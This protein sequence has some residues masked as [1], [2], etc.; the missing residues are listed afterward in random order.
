MTVC[1]FD[2]DDVGATTLNNAAGS[3]DAVLYSALVTGYNAKSIT[4]LSV[5]GG[6]ATATCAGHGYSASVG[7]SVDIVGV[8][9]AALNGRKQP[10]TVTSGAFTYAAVGVADTGSAGGTIT[11]KRSPLGWARVANASNKS[12]Y[13]RTDVAATAQ[14]LCLDDSGAGNA[15]T[16]YARI[17]MAEAWTAADAFTGLA[18]TV[19]Q[20]AGGQVVGKGANSTTAKKWA[21]FG[22]SQFLYLFTEAA[23]FSF[24]STGALTMSCF[25][26][27]VSDRAGDAY[28]SI[29]SASTS[30]PGDLL[31]GVGR[32]AQVGA[33]PGANDL[34]FSRLSNQLG[35]AVRGLATGLLSG[36][37]AGSSGPAYP[38]PV[39]NGAALQSP[40]LVCEE[41]ASF[42]HPVRGVLP[43]LLHPLCRGLNVL[44]MTALPNVA[45]STRSLV[46]VGT[47]NQSGL[48]AVVIDTTGPWR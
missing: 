36:G 14:V 8:A 21:I 23:G 3:L 48:G 32:S 25:G 13:A 27:I 17:V 29:I 45:G 10:L 11:A 34:C 7:K 6:I 35:T 37:Q 33:T 30:T 16:T 26:D 15:G 28:R 40:V 47:T 44:H 9:V 39:N 42:F 4:S 20:L 2:S 38:S 19:A 43:G 41:N 22:D 31:S 46:V 24:A 1:W 5:S 12:I 18:P